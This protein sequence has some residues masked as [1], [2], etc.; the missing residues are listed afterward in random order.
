[1]KEQMH[2]YEA[3]KKKVLKQFKKG[4]NCLGKKEPFR[5][6]WRGLQTRAFIL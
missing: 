1:M 4:E 5:L 2:D 3:P 6:C